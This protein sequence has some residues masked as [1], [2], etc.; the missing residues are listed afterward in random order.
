MQAHSIDVD[1]AEP[2]IQHVGP[3]HPP[4]WQ[5]LHV[6]GLRRQQVI[7]DVGKCLGRRIRTAVESGKCPE[8]GKDLLFGQTIEIVNAL[9]SL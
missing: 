1:P 7:N 8:T 5:L 9:S 6:R 2:Q 4:L 3:L